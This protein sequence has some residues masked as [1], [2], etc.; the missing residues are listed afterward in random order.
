[1]ET[2]I[3]TRH[4]SLVELLVERGV[5][6]AGTPVI[7][8]ATPD[9][10]RGRH[11]IG[12]LPMHLAALAAS[13]T[14]V[15]VNMTLEDREAAQAGDLPLERLREIAGP[16]VRYIVASHGEA[17]VPAEWWRTEMDMAAC[18]F[19]MSQRSPDRALVFRAW[20]ALRSVVHEADA[21]MAGGPIRLSSVE[22]SPDELMR[23]VE[24]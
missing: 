24:D 22:R 3:V 8:H 10:V 6:P 12:V 1:M 9:D 23:T 5:C 20:R 2:V 4:P 17:V 16:A 21:L 19:D 7:E 11:V 18:F 14:E 13:V 15:K